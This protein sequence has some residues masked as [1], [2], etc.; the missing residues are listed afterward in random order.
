MA[1]F[2]VYGETIFLA[3]FNCLLSSTGS[4][5]NLTVIL[6]YLFCSSERGTTDLL[7]VSLSVSDFL[8]C[9]VYQPVFIHDFLSVHGLPPH[10]RSVLGY[11]LMTASL[12]GL[13]AVTLDRF[14]AI[15]YPYKYPTLMAPANAKRVIV[16]V[17]F[18][19]AIKGVLTL[20]SF[21]F[22]MR[23][24]H[25]YVTV[26]MLG[27]PITYLFI[28]RET[29]KQQRQINNLQTPPEPIPDA[30]EEP[31]SNSV[32]KSSSAAPPYQ[33]ELTPH[34]ASGSSGEQTRRTTLA[35]QDSKPIAW[36]ETARSQPE[37]AQGNPRNGVTEAPTRPRLQIG[38]A[39]RLVGL[40]LVTTW[41]AWLPFCLFPAVWPADQQ[42]RGL[43]WAIT[44]ASANS[45][46][47]PLLYCWMSRKFR[48]LVRKAW[49]SAWDRVKDSCA[50]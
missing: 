50:R 42:G 8:L 10:V 21:H 40:V 20:V 46:M 32:P 25:L 35:P 16:V 34:A 37:N 1:A 33:P 41:M 14:V 17:W 47:N 9:S 43:V 48:A 31:D 29:N 44:T 3:V 18:S 15:Y 45:C 26:V 28:W 6:A 49:R 11:G 39:T 30:A 24:C 38:R 27:L 4:I 19:A 13:V 5:A 12:N 7:L 36:P 22:V 23:G 2:G